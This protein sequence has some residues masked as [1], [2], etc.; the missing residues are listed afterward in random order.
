MLPECC[1]DN[2]GNSVRMLP[3]YAMKEEDFSKLYWEE[4]LDIRKRNSE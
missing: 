3:K 4:N 1:P 2:S